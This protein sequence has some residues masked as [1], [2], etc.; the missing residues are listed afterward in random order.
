LV[1]ELDGTFASRPLSEWKAALDAARLAYGVVQIPSEIIADPQLY[2]NN[3]VVPIADGSATPR[4][5]VNSPVTVREEPKVPPRLAPGLGEHS[6]EVLRELGYD[7]QQIDGL[8]A[9]GA[10]PAA[11]K[12]A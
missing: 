12:A 10:V 4:Y 7:A 6:E 9:S 11:P 2:A 3:I 5:T 8:S 1:N